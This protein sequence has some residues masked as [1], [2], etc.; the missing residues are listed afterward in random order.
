ML[1]VATPAW[2]WFLAKTRSRARKPFLL[3]VLLLI[4]NLGLITT[5]GQYRD[6]VLS[7]PASIGLSPDIEFPQVPETPLNN[8]QF[9]ERGNRVDR[10]AQWADLLIKHPSQPRDAF[11]EA[12]V[13][14]FPY[15]A[16]ALGSIYTPWSS[17]S[18]KTGR[19]AASPSFVICAGS[20]N[21]H[22]AAHLVRGLRRVHGSKTAIE[23][24]YAGDDDLE[25]EHRSFLRDLEPNVSFID[26][27]Q[28]FPA[29]R[30][31][32]EGSGW[33]MK[34]FALL[35]A[36]S[37]RAVLMDA[38]AVFLTSPDSLFDGAQPHPGLQRTG[39]LFFHDRAARAGEHKRRLWVQAQL[40]AA[41]RQPSAHLATESLFYR[42]ETW[43]EQDSGLVAVD[44]TN[45][46]AALG[47]VFAAWM[48]TKAVRD[49]VTYRTFHGDK[50]TFWLAMELSGLDYFFQ[51]W[52]AGNVGTIS[53][54]Q[55]QGGEADPPATEEVQICG[56]H[57]LH[58][59]RLGETP[60][61]TNGGLYAHKAQP[62][63]GYAEMTHYMAGGL[64][65]VRPEWSFPNP[66]NA[67]LNGTGARPLP[68]E[69]KATVRRLRDEASTVDEMIK[70]LP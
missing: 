49:Q 23:I 47:L 11:E 31:D 68:E 69:I 46:R 45:P 64:G 3:V 58:L 29:A 54:Q 36:A 48:N 13:R 15:L 8:S 20:R 14:Q 44:R 51:P 26:L 7:W 10:L 35:A 1:R 59:D 56:S 30:Q 63:L 4:V 16:G 37:S 40:E 38:D 53:Q 70:R 32:L 19:R 43:W 18:G 28:R 55:P 39:T 34:P 33:A 67:C 21:F 65:G 24:A 12:L 27:L 22:L 9:G 50:E 5:L 41:G 66:D 57:M 25:A 17:A 52:Y 60:F 6:L 42:A 2:T 62:E 61:W